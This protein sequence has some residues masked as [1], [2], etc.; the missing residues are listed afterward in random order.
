MSSKYLS[1]GSHFIDKKDITAVSKAL[2][3]KLITSGSL[4]QNFEK[5]FLNT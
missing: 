1:Y 2:K 3:N 5:K 4:V